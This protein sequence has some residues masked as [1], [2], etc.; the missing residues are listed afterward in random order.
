MKKK[1]I[2]GH[3]LKLPQ[4]TDISCPHCGFVLG[5]GAFLNTSDPCFDHSWSG[6]DYVVVEGV[7]L[8]RNAALVREGAER[9]ICQDC[10]VNRRR[11]EGPWPITQE[12]RRS[13]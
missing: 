3:E 2:C 12:R 7:R 13:V 5:R 9:T 4:L 11:T 8:D 1:S 6:G 10:P